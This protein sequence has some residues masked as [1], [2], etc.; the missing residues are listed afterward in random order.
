MNRLFLTLG[1][2]GTL[3]TAS[4]AQSLNP[5][6]PAPLQPGEN[7]ATVDN[8]VGGHYW[9]CTVG[10]GKATIHVHVSSF[11]GQWHSITVHV[12]DAAKTWHVDKVIDERHPDFDS[13]GTLK[14]STRI[15]VQISPPGAGQVLGNLTRSGA[16]YE[17]EVTGAVKFGAAS[18]A[19]PIVRAYQ[20]MAGFTKA[21]GGTRFLADGTIVTQ[22]GDHGTW[23]LFDKASRSYVVKMDG[24]EMKTL[25]YVPGR[26]LV[27]SGGLIIF[28]EL[29]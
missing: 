16:E 25:Q 14:S 27:E 7:Q 15:V 24:Q 22:D 1:L 28:Q 13:P 3:V 8:E 29:R 18:H 19:D 11:G 23:S 9:G 6:A 4:Q 5:S 17:I 20:E 26:G 2:V 12:Y 21:F 10:P